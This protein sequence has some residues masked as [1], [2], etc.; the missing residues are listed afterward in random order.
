M[1]RYYK[2]DTQEIIDLVEKHRCG[3]ITYVDSKHKYHSHKSH[4]QYLQKLNENDMIP[5][6]ENLIECYK[7]FPDQRTFLIALFG[8]FIPENELKLLEQEEK[9]KELEKQLENCK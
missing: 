4:I 2:T 9:I 3:H 7:N 6:K 1:N 8:Q 5:T